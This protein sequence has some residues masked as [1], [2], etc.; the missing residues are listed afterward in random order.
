MDWEIAY[1]HCQVGSARWKWR[2]GVLS[3][4]GKIYCAPYESHEATLAIDPAKL[5]VMAMAPF[6]GKAIR[7]FFDVFRRSWDCWNPEDS[8]RWSLHSKLKQFLSKNN[9]FRNSEGLQ[10][11]GFVESV[12]GSTQLSLAAVKLQRF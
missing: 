4:D 7:W 2:G 8:E 1:G 3:S 11:P 10:L 12:Q 5:G 9:D 6:D